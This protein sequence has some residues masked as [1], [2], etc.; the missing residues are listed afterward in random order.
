VKVECGEAKGKA[1][2]NNI[3]RTIEYKLKECVI[4]TIIKEYIEENMALKYIPH[5]LRR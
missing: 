4:Y 1:A 3:K 2:I 5:T